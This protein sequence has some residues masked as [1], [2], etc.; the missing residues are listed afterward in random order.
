M[1]FITEI[2]KHVKN[3]YPKTGTPL[4]LHPPPRPPLLAF[5][6]LAFPPR[7]QVKQEGDWLCVLQA[8]A[9]GNVKIITMLEGAGGK[10][11]M[12]NASGMTPLAYSAGQGNVKALQTLIDRGANLHTRNK[13]GTTPLHQAASSGNQVHGCTVLFQP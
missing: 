3:M 12:R 10:V 8:A 4:L 2:V 13:D 9:C 7:K 1:Q 6:P 11:D 5:P